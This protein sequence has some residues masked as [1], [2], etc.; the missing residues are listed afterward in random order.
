MR[1]FAASRT[2]LSVA[3]IIL[4]WGVGLS[5]VAYAKSPWEVHWAG[6]KPDL[7]SRM[8]RV[9]RFSL[10]K[11]AVPHMKYRVLLPMLQAFADGRKGEAKYSALEATWSEFNLVFSVVA[12]ASTFVEHAMFVS[13]L[14]GI[15][16]YFTKAGTAL[17]AL[18]VI[19]DISA[20]NHKAALVNSYKTVQGYWIGT[21]GTAGMQIG[22]VAGFVVDYWLTDVRETTWLNHKNQLRKIYVAYY[23]DTSSTEIR[24]INDWKTIIYRIYDKSKFA[25]IRNKNLSKKTNTRKKIREEYFNNR[26]NGELDAYI[27]KIWNSDKLVFYKSEN[28][29]LRQFHRISKVDKE[30][31]QAEYKTKLIRQFTRRIFPELTRR[32][33]KKWAEHELEYNMN[34][35][36]SYSLVSKLNKVFVL[37]VRAYGLKQPARLIIHRPTGKPWKGTIRP[38]RKVGVKMTKIA[39]I[40]AGL[41]DKIS[42]VVGDKTTTLPFHFG[43]DDK[44]AIS[45]GVPKIVAVTTYDR[46]ES[47]QTCK[48][49]RYHLGKKPESFT[50]NRNAVSGIVHMT[51]SPQGETIIGH[52]SL[53]ENKWLEY[54][55]GKTSSLKLEANNL[56]AMDIAGKMKVDYSV[57]FSPP[58]FDD[59]VALEKCTGQASMMGRSE[60]ACTVRRYKRTQVSRKV[61]VERRCTSTITLKSKNMFLT[62]GNMKGQIV[63][64]ESK[65]MKQ[66]EREISKGVK[67][68]QDLLQRLPKQ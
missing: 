4:F 10:K 63:D 2:V 57:H 35:A 61:L 26:V 65:A 25:R 60:L 46:Q 18:Q 12:N 38:G 44:A 53:D 5:S 21:L 17:G 15:N 19:L 64:F 47:A 20:N 36:G 13:G 40:R 24:N 32:S 56:N 58:Y 27:T 34:G 66:N 8:L 33:W 30:A 43:K 14:S 1:I 42:M 52:Y 45:F 49:M 3:L 23:K 54:S 11:N 41:P 37:E 31:L 16:G 59:I 62:T 50:E 9:E 22:G 55:V 28:I 6:K 29:H 68:M 39:F 51:S 48:G 7:D 67:E